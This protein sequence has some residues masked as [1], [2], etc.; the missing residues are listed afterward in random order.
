MKRVIVLL[1]GALVFVAACAA[2]APTATPTS[3]PAAAATTKAPTATPTKRPLVK[4]V[5]VAANIASV[6]HV[7]S[8]VA[9]AKGLFRDEGLDVEFVVTGAGPATTGALVSGSADFGTTSIESLIGAIA[10]GGPVIIIGQTNTVAIAATMRKDVAERLGITEKSPLET[11]ARA[12]KGL[13]IT[14]VSPAGNTGRVARVL[15]LSVGLDPDRDAEFTYIAKEPDMLA[16]M[17][18]KRVDV[19]STSVP[20]SLIPAIEGYGVVIFALGQEPLPGME[21][22]FAGLGTNRDLASKRPDVMEAIVRAQ[23]RALVSLKQDPEDAIQAL[24]QNLERFREAD[25]RALRMS[26]QYTAFP[27]DPSVTEDVVRAAVESVNLDR[28][29][30]NKISVTFDQVATNRFVQ[31]AKKQLGY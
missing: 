15:M 14:S 3:S 5:W 16:A 11:R 18:E 24:K 8:H 10:E 20:A 17:Q 1:L 28:P 23:W 19:I 31:A 4:A 6:A 21:P 25:I 30:G 12:L 13:T 7:V 9:D 22:S 29:A 27:S 26:V 2:P